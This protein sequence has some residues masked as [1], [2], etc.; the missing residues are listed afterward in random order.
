M[1]PLVAFVA[2]MA[3]AGVDAV[4]VR[5][6]DWPDARLLRVT[7]AAVGAV[8]GSTCRV[9]VN[10]RAHV[11]VAA[12]A[13]GVHLRGTGMPVRRVRLAWP[14]G[15]LIGRSVHLGDDDA[16]VDGADMVMFGMVFPS[17]SKAPDAPVA[18]LRGAGRLGAPARHGTG[19]GRRGHRGRS[20]R[21]GA[22]DAGACGI[23]GID[24]FVRAWQQGPSALAA[25][26]REIH[27]VFR[28]RERA[29]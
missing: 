24:L 27:A 14:T 3:V 17:G 25:V 2:A 5:E 4:Q 9:L 21:G 8:Q 28:D 7:R 16:D 22:R 12:D 10:E 11:A 20:L 6:R 15:L 13:H 19:R 26:V 29:E 18:G 1:T 23:A